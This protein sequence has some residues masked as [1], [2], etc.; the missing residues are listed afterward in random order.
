ML[1]NFSRHAQVLSCPQSAVCLQT[2][3][4]LAS[5]IQGL[6][7][8]GWWATQLM[9]KQLKKTNLRHP[10]E[11]WMHTY[12]INN[13]ETLTYMFYSPTPCRTQRYVEQSIGDLPHQKPNQNWMQGLMQEPFYTILILHN[14][15]SHDIIT[16]MSWS[17]AFSFWWEMPWHMCSRVMLTCLCIHRYPQLT[18]CIPAW[19][20][21][22]NFIPQ[23]LQLWHSPPGILVYPHTEACNLLKWCK[24]DK[25][26]VCTWYKRINTSKIRTSGSYMTTALGLLL[27]VILKWLC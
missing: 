19:P 23:F 6:M 4:V 27:N 16:M 20:A 15:N 18:P 8:A 21:K 7:N 26:H 2:A 1:E 17:S 9:H 24:T 25:I 14:Q 10:S 3:A 22:F 13:E 11:L 5:L 12:K